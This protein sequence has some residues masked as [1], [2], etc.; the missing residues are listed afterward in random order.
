MS[1]AVCA[2]SGGCIWARRDH[3][4]AVMVRYACVVANAYAAALERVYQK[5]LTTQTLMGLALKQ[6]QRS[7]NSM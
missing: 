6:F 5:S 4:A 1:V 3:G 2:P 7:W